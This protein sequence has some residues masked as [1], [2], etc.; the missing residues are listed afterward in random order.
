MLYYMMHACI[1]SIPY[2]DPAMFL[3]LTLQSEWLDWHAWLRT[4]FASMVPELS[5]QHLVLV[6]YRVLQVKG[7]ID[8]YQ[9]S[10]IV[11]ISGLTLELLINR[12]IGHRT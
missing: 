11:G 2:F 12:S 4:N 3:R 7:S 9:L 8:A 10:E 6:Q 1:F 5:I